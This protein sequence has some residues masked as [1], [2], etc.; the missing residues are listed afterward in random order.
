MM[1]VCGFTLIEML[2]VLV[3]MA[4]ITSFAWPAYHQQVLKTRRSTGVGALVELA[5]RLEHYY[6]DHST[7]TG[8][9]LGTQAGSIFPVMTRNGYY[10]L[11]IANQND[12]TFLISATPTARGKQDSDKCGAFT[13]DSLGNRGLQGNTIAFQ[14]CW[15]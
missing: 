5:A 8:A 1:K 9:S 3:I 10:R 11:S 12:L 7:Y 14:L 6:I 13:L 15:N 4:I 2:I